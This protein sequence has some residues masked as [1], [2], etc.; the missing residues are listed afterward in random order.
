LIINYLIPKFNRE[1]GNLPTLTQ[2][3]SKRLAS[4]LR[5]IRPT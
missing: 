4:P 3:S 5:K 2:A 1:H